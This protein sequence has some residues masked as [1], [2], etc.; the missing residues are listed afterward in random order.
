M[1]IFWYFLD[2][3]PRTTFFLI[4]KHLHRRFS[5]FLQEVYY[6]VAQKRGD[7]LAGLCGTV[8]HD[9]WKS[10]FTLEGVQ[11][12][13]CNAHHLRELKAL[14]EIEKEAWAFRMSRLLKRLLKCHKAP[15]F[16]RVM[17]LYDRIIADGLEFHASQQKLSGRKRRIGHNLLLRLQKFKNAVLRFLFTPGVP[18]TNNQAEQDIRMIKVKQKISG[19][20]STL[21]GA[22]LLHYQRLSLYST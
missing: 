8:V 1:R 21:Y 5:L 3:A 12:A 7:L 18:F 16:E 10:Y 14:E 17:T 13:L 9:H 22:N 2:L 11:H 15:P 4:I 20:F 19:C 6:R